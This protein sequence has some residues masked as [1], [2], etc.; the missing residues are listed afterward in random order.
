MKTPAATPDLFAPLPSVPSALALRIA[1][2]AQRKPS[3]RQLW[4]AVHFPDLALEALERDVDERRPH[5]VIDGSG[6]AQRIAACDRAAAR[7]GVRPGMA[8]NAA[9]AL[10]PRLAARARQPR[11]E[12]R[13]LERCAAWAGQFTPLVSIEPPDALLLEVRGSLGL[14]GGAAA[15]CERISSARRPVRS[16]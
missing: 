7:A 12:E 8:L 13:L 4:V 15:L 5:A 16:S 11:S 10:A 9:F 6:S 14:F 2:E 3:A 1:P